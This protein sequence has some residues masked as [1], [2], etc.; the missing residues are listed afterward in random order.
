MES[1]QRYYCEYKKGLLGKKHYISIE[2]FGDAVTVCGFTSFGDEYSKPQTSTIRIPYEKLVDARVTKV[3]GMIYINISEKSG[4]QLYCPGLDD[5]EQI[6]EE[7]KKAKQIHM[8][9]LQQIER[10][11]RVDREIKRQEIEKAVNESKEYYNKCFE[12]HI[13]NEDNPYCILNQ[14]SNLLCAIYLDRDRNLNIL[15]IDGNEKTEICARIEYDKIHYFEKAGAIHYVSTVDGHY[16]NYGG[17]F[18]GATFSKSAT[19]LGGLLFGTMGL[20]GGALLSAKPS[21]YS[22]PE[23]KIDI[24]STIQ[25]INDKNVLLNYYSDMRKQF[26]DMQLP[27]EAYNFLQTYIPEKRYEIVTELEKQAAI[28]K[29]KEEIVEPSI[30]GNGQQK[31]SMDEFKASV[32]K[33]KYMYESGMITEDVYETKKIELMNQI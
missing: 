15:K 19:V 3:N 5:P 22:T 16:K 30:K 18:T 1:I 7:I 4:T 8:Q 11:K 27:S 10:N 6:C 24:S 12:F 23:N 29:N 13:K 2:I 9:K 32:D 21:S 33:L 31:I 20:A 26:L 28:S 14:A 17:D 25:Q